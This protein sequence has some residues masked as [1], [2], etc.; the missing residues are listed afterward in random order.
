MVVSGKRYIFALR[1]IKN[2][3]NQ[4]L[5]NVI[6]RKITSL[7]AALFCLIGTGALAQDSERL[8]FG[9]ISDIHFDNG[10]G[11]GAMVKVPQ[12]LKNLTSQGKLDALAIAGDL[13]DAGR[14]DQ[15]EMLVSVFNDKSNYTNPVG[16]LLFMMGNHDH[17]NASG[18]SNYQNGLSVFNGGEPYP[19]HQYKVIKGYPFITISMMT[20]GSNAYPADL[21]KQLDTWLTQAASEC[22]GKP[23]FVFTHV[24]PQWTVYGSWPEFENGS[25]WGMADLNSV[26]NKYPQAVVFAGHSHYPLGD[27][28]SI[29]QGTNPDS[30]HKNYYTAINTASTTYGE[31]HPGAVAAGI[32]PENFAY[33]TEGMIVS[34]MEDGNIEIRRFDTYR[35]TEINPEKRWVLKAPFDGSMFEYADI[36]DA[37]DNPDNV[38]L[39]N[40]LPAPA[41]TKSAEIG[42]EFVDG[43]AVVSFPQATDDECVFRYRLRIFKDGLGVS[44]RF[45]F[46]Q[47]YLYS[48]MPSELSYTITGLTK[49]SE[50]RVE[51]VAYDSYDNM[52]DPLMKTFKASSDVVSSGPDAQ[53]KFDDPNNLLKGESD[54]FVMQPLTVGNHSVTLL[55]SL[56]EAGITTVD[57]PEAGY[58]AIF[59]PKNSGLL[60]QRPEGSPA[61]SDYTIMFYVKMPDAVS[62]NGLFQTNKNN[63]NDGELFIYRNKIGM[64][65]MGGYFSEIKDDTWYRIFM[66]YRNGVVNVY[67]NDERVLEHSGDIRWEIDPWG[68]YF[69]TD[70][71]G[72]MSDTH[73][74][75]LAFWERSISD[76]EIR[77]ACKLP[78]VELTPFIALKT[79]N[80]KVVDNLEFKV[81]I[82]SNTAFTFDLPDWIEGVDITPFMGTHDYTFR[83]QPMEYD[84]RREGVITVKAE[85]VEPQ[86][87]KVEQ[88]YVGDETP[89]PLGWWTFDN[90][91]SLMYEEIGFGGAT[92]SPAFKGADGPEKTYDAEKAGIT[93]V[94]G[95]TEG[96]GAVR[97]PSNSYLWVNT[98]TGLA[99]MS[100]YTILYD[101]MLND[102]NGYKSMLQ[103][104]VKN[105]SDACFFFKNNQLGRGGNL[106][107]Y[108]DF[109][110]DVWYRILFVVKDGCPTAYVNGVKLSESK[111]FVD[112][113]VIHND[114]FL[115]FADEDGEEGTVNVASIRFWDVPLSED[116]AKKLGDPYS[117]VEQLFVVQTQNVR[118]FDNPEFSININSNVPFTF[119]L[120][121]WIEAL[122]IEPVQGEKDYI[123]RAQPLEQE[124]RREGVITIEAEDFDP[125]EVPVIQ[126][127]LGNEMPEP[128]SVWTFDNPGDLL[129][130]TGTAVLKPA[131]KNG[132]GETEITDLETAEILPTDGPLD[133][134][135][136]IGINADSYL[137]LINNSGFAELKDFAIQFDIRP[138]TL[139]EPDALYQANFKNNMDA[140][141]FIN[142][143]MVG[144][145]T[146]GL[147][148]H[149]EL[150]YMKWHRIFFVV[151]QG[152]A[153]V[154][155]DGDKVGQSTSPNTMWSMYPEVLLFADESGE[156]SYNELCELRFWDV[157]LSD[158]QVKSLGG[159][160][161]D[162]EDDP[163]DDPTGVWTFDDPNNLLAGTGT[164][165]LKGA[166]RG[167]EGPEVVDDLASIGIVPIEGPSDGNGA[168]T[169]PLD[170]YLQ[171][172][173]NE[174]DPSQT[175]FTFLMDIR[176]K[177]LKG[178]NVLLQTDPTNRRDG[179]LFTKDTQI[180][181][182]VAGLGYADGLIQDKWQRIVFVVNDC[183]M[184]GVYIDGQKVNGTQT[185]QT[186][187]WS[188]R[189]VCYIFADENGEEGPVDIA[190]L[191]FWNVAISSAQ[192]KAMGAAGTKTG[193]QQIPISR[194]L[195]KGIYDLTGRK[196]STPKSKLTKGV[197]II[198]GKAVLVE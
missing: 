16:D 111:N 29:H 161:Q 193:M 3:Y 192:V 106:G 184:T 25:T 131:Y 136:A 127:K 169:V 5:N 20:S 101:V 129:A 13:A 133:G 51:V 93:F 2:K 99:D 66:V 86:E 36:R 49:D 76:N 8:T 107:Y 108:G 44:E 187:Y 87:I 159:V 116:M 151:R 163:F 179:V 57:G 33:A 180:G 160:E 167:A 185:P 84:G 100:S 82:E 188:L 55:E 94:P 6:M 189:D 147:G 96:N 173:H 71:D 137:C 105:T 23:I 130:G 21:R 171:M 144:R 92:M 50:Y 42:V 27:P 158:E 112:Y 53:W 138:R 45:I 77:E 38:P 170:S 46:S 164:A 62:Y 72:E 58:G 183:A 63:N 182:N 64:N 60:M 152:Y 22:P 39:R 18:M 143:G 32:H 172:A 15:Y 177:L 124:G 75:E 74:A 154:Y 186:D 47:F 89:E 41:F 168:A 178:F 79:S 14:A 110:T 174:P 176:P 162:W 61:T 91:N 123:F 121:D 120:P 150:T 145:N 88:L 59:V 115:L 165:T 78:P 11:E 30:P 132:D 149:G 83:A 24:P 56:E 198:D 166:K 126:I 68:F 54:K 40:G 146:N 191:Q 67:V 69:L 195:P 128:A 140:G 52:S 117:D 148:Y 134:N 197:Y 104:N 9:V 4:T 35:N 73:V 102:L 65:A 97:V 12:A 142:K 190:E 37:A 34:E 118:L 48:G 109:Q 31:I 157:P 26:L 7:L 70:E 141:L 113:D 85:G 10:I 135:G 122:D 114:E 175:S 196:I 194:K 19:L 28:R 95:P 153:S 17:G 103:T 1:E 98:A 80:V 125:V 90:P 43:K 81:T 181:I 139:Q 119:Q 155:I 156:E